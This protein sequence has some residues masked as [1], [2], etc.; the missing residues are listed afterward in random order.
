M[1]NSNTNFLKTAIAY[2]SLIFLTSLITSCSE[3]YLDFSDPINE[4]LEDNTL[5]LKRTVTYSPG[6]GLNKDIY[7]YSY[8]DSKLLEWDLTRITDSDTIIITYTNIYDGDLI[9][10]LIQS[11]PDMPETNSFFFEYDENNNLISQHLNGHLLM[12]YAHSENQVNIFHYV[13]ILLKEQIYDDNNNLIR[14]V[15]H[16]QGTNPYQRT[17]TF[18][19]KNNPF[20]NATA[21]F[22]LTNLEDIG[23][24][25]ITST[26]YQGTVLRREYDYNINDY[27]TYIKT[28]EYNNRY[29]IEVLEYNN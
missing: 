11:S 9:S 28:E 20:K 21:R 6:Y 5:C 22:P 18:D 1:N 26:S 10:N 16:N 27:P 13:G 8:E 24:N 14:V 7:E 12:T 29:K 4:K 17:Y 2:L 19:N 3:P 15:T 25:N 23:D